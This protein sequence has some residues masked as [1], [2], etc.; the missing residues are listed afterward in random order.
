MDYEKKAYYEAYKRLFIH[1]DAKPSLKQFAEKHQIQD[2]QAFV[3]YGRRA[4][5][6]FD[7]DVYQ[8]N[9]SN[10][11]RDRMMEM[12]SFDQLSKLREIQAMKTNA[13]EAAIKLTFKHAKDA[14]NSYTELEKLERLILGQ[15][16]ENISMQDIT[17]YMEAVVSVLIQE[18]QLEAP[19]PLMR[20][21]TRLEQLTFGNMKTARS[22]GEAN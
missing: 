1:D 19:V 4:D 15:S 10:K 7:R 11:V 5:W 2:V 3:Q 9:L 12:Q 21:Q 14:I 20:I 13:W 16:T 22:Q 8:D 6:E 17:V 18:L